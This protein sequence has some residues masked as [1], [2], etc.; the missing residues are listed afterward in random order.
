MKSVYNFARDEILAR[1][2]AVACSTR[3][4]GSRPGWKMLWSCGAPP[5]VCVFAWKAARE[6][7]AT[8]L[9]KMKRHMEVDGVCSI[10]GQEDESVHHALV[11]CPHA[12]N[13]WNVMRVVWDL[14]SEEVLSRREPD[15][16]LLLLHELSETQ[17]MLVLMVLW[18]A[19]HIHNELTHDK[20][21]IPV[22]VSKRFL[23]DYVQSLLTI[24]HYPHADTIKGKL[25][26]L[27]ELSNFVPVTSNTK[28]LVSPVAWE[29]PPDGHVKLNFDGSFVVADGSAGAGMVLRDH[30][31]HVI[32][33]GV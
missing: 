20:P 28:C 29:P 17:R 9:N 13:L 18:R 24:K 8:R 19:W 2:G 12:R 11:R 7:L 14:P 16:L 10:C 31:G 5:K 6:A 27:T 23:C 21:L 1:H 33:C 32:F 15:W 30:L 26:V 22:E 3:P 4:D 25:P